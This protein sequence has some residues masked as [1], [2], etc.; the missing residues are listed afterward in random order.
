MKCPKCQAGNRD[1]DKFCGERVAP[2]TADELQP[3]EIKYVMSFVKGSRSQE[4]EATKWQE[5]RVV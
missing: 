2:L 3:V 5:K 4:K 1:T